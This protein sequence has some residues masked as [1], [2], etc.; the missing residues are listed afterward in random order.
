[1]EMVMLMVIGTLMHTLK[2]AQTMDLDITKDFGVMFEE[3]GEVHFGQS[4]F[5]LHYPLHLEVYKNKLIKYKEYLA[6]SHR[7]VI[8][9]VRTVSAIQDMPELT[10]NVAMSLFGMGC[11]V[12]DWTV[13]RNKIA[14]A[15]NLSFAQCIGNCQ[16]MTQCTMAAYEDMTCHNFGQIQVN[17][18]VHQFKHIYIKYKKT[19]SNPQ[20]PRLSYAAQIFEHTATR[21]Y[22]SL[23]VALNNIYLNLN[24]DDSSCRVINKM[25]YSSDSYF[26][27]QT[28]SSSIDCTKICKQHAF[29]LFSTYFQSSSL[30]KLGSFANSK[31][32][33]LEN[34]ITSFEQCSTHRVKRGLFNFVGDALSFLFGTGTES[35]VHEVEQ[36]I[37]KLIQNGQ[38]IITITDKQ[39]VLINNLEQVQEN[40]NQ[41]LSSLASSFSRVQ[42]QLNNNL[43]AINMLQLQQLQHNAAIS[44]SFSEQEILSTSM[45]LMKDFIKLD[46]ITHSLLARQIPQSIFNAAQWH[47]LEHI[48]Q[49]NIPADWEVLQEWQHIRFKNIISYIKVKGNVIINFHVP[50]DRA[51]H[52]FQLYHIYA[53]GVPVPDNSIALKL[54][55]DIKYFAHNV[56]KGIV[57]LKQNELDKCICSGNDYFCQT[58]FI[59]F[60]HANHGEINC[61]KSLFYHVL[62]DI[63]TACNFTTVFYPHFELIHTKNAWLYSAPSKQTVTRRCPL[64]KTSTSST[65]EPWI[66]Q[67]VGLIKLKSGCQLISDHGYTALTSSFSAN[68]TLP[69]YI[70]PNKIYSPDI[71]PLVWHSLFN[72]SSDSSEAMVNLSSVTTLLHNNQMVFSHNHRSLDEIAQLYKKIRSDYPSFTNFFSM[73][74]AI[75]IT[76]T[77]TPTA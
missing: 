53:V 72:L 29:C 65:S 70:A 57:L 47:N 14:K 58:Q 13:G 11:L 38:D 35:Q 27:E 25:C 62:S 67:N 74:Y 64:L 6:K 41:V 49:Q 30:C 43:H 16:N 23:Y 50:L 44:I 45:I 46:R 69:D 3:R 26:Y 73:P 71:I 2:Y 54:H 40:M 8:S 34:V 56:Q 21:H 39:A 48:I 59:Y 19:C 28:V 31:L 4:E 22:K 55:S 68:L 18:Q 61:L 60:R 33:H 63:Q 12:H 32:S 5:L 37:N 15:S 17:E 9:L 52:R 66:L 10:E 76:G 24:I 7:E 36:K 20:D 51:T 75:E 42:H 1:M 77:G